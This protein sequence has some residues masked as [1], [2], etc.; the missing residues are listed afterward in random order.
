[1]NELVILAIISMFFPAF[2]LVYG[3]CEVFRQKVIHKSKKNNKTNI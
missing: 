2:M 3:M 1:M